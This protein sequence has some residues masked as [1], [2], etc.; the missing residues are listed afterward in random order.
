MALIKNKVALGQKPVPSFNDAIG[1]KFRTEI[2]FN[3]ADYNGVT[4]V[5]NDIIDM[6]TLPSDVQ[7]LDYQIDSDDLD[8]NGSPAI[9]YSFG[10]L[11][12][13]KTDL[14]VVFA[15]GITIS[16]AGGLARATSAL[17]LRQTSGLNVGFKITTAAAT[18]AKGKLGVTMDVRPQY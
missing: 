17:H 8:S 10:L 13:A 14:A 15:S 1:G 11:N 7:L 16:Q 9:A 3:D 5:A 12:A 6:G 18:F 4:P 2:D